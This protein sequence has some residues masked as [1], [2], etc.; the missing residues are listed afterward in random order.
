VAVLCCAQ[1]DVST[2][3]VVVTYKPHA[4]PK[5]RQKI[6]EVLFETFEAPM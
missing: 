5:E 6:A 4:S 2:K 3:A 1:V